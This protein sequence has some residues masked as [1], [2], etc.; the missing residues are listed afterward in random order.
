MNNFKTR[1]TAVLL[2]GVLG[3]M[4]AGLSSFAADADEPVMCTVSFDL[5]EEGVTLDEGDVIEDLTVQYGKS[6]FLPTVTPQREGYRFT[7]WTLDGIQG[8]NAGDV[9]QVY[10]DCTYKPVWIDTE[11]TETHAIT[12]KVEINGEVLDTSK[13]LPEGNAVAGRILQVA[14]KSYENYDALQYGWLV[15]GKELRSGQKFIVPDHDIEITPS[16][17]YYHTITYY[18]GDVDRV[19]GDL[20]GTVTRAEGIR[21][22]LAQSSKLTRYGFDLTGWVCSADGLTYQPAGSFIMTYEDVTMTAVWTPI[23][24]NVV[25]D[26]QTT[27]SD[28]QKIPGQTDTTITVP[29]NIAVK[30]GYYFDGWVYDDEVYYPGDEY[31]IVGAAPGVGIKF[32]ANW[33]EGED[34]NVTTTTTTT[35]T[36]VTTTTT[37]EPD[38]T[39]TPPT[40]TQKGDVNGDGGVD[41]ADATY[42][43]QFLANPDDFKLSVTQSEAADVDGNNDGVTPQDALVIQQLLSGIIS[44]LPSAEQ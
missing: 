2:S 22:D 18:A 13:D 36:T 38:V 41:V 9:I 32:T 20:S 35:T 15:Q 10:E 12:Y 28:I 44:E 7:G 19:S 4:S 3:T 21:T 34:P 25:F 8:Y 40:P 16:W 29:E 23:N 17:H 1:L 24:Y 30:K 26:P 42:V 27:S 5:S 37:A 11:D 14:K 39:T 43:M 31:L 33:V 6:E